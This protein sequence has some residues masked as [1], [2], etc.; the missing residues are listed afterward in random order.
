[1]DFAYRDPREPLDLL[2]SLTL[3][4]RGLVYILS[5]CIIFLDESL[6]LYVKAHHQRKEEEKV[7]N[8]FQTYFIT[9][10]F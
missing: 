5:K 9:C 6:F 7:S 4:K 8:I 1:M 2:L 3:S 10:H